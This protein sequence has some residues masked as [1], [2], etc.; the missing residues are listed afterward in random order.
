M[1]ISDQQD[2]LR[3]A[4]IQTDKEKKEKTDLAEE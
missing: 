4:V 1:L 3:A 2:T